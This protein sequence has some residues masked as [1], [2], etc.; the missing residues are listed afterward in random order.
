VFLTRRGTPHLASNAGWAFK[1]D[2]QRAGAAV[3]RGEGPYLLR[4]T[5]A[6]HLLAEG[7]PVTEVAMLMGHASAAT[8]MA[9]YAH[10]VRND[11]SAAREA[12]RRAYGL[13]G[14]VAV[15]APP[16]RSPSSPGPS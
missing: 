3:R 8:T 11:L 12:I 6:S 16:T 1:R 13:S 9:V 10:W 5:Y 2:A 4:H 15:P 14:L 7:R